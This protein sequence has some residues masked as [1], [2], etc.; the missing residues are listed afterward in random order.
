MCH[1]WIMDDASD[2]TTFVLEDP[3]R[4]E[5]A[6]ACE[7]SPLTKS[8]IGHILNRAPG[9]LTAIATLEK[10]GA[11][12]RAGRA[13]PRGSRLGGIR[14]QLNPSWVPAV[15][16]AHVEVRSGQ[17][18]SGLDVVLVPAAQTYEASKALSVG[19]V[20][21]AWGAPLDGEQMGLLLC[22]SAEPDE[23]RTL[24]L[25]SDLAQR[26]VNGIRLRIRTLLPERELRDWA[27]EI[28]GESAPAIAAP[29]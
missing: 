1:T 18:S 23:G 15:R 13:A 12:L 22:A 28:T 8:Q 10:R 24:R 2:R 29:E 14:W 11:L 19:D 3:V 6:R 4:L 7:Q 9:G 21:A 27:E 25:L 17:L 5:I 16:A 26:N 20:Q